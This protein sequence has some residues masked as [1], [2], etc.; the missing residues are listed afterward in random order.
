MEGV[1]LVVIWLVLAAVLNVWLVWYWAL[2]VAAGVLV[3]GVVVVTS[4]MFDG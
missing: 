2:L 1:L 4:G 3:L